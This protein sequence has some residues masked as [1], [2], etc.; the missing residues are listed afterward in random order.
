MLNNIIPKFIR[1]VPVVS[2]S[3][4]ILHVNWK[5][6]NGA[7]T[8]NKTLK[9]REDASGISNF[10][11]DK[12]LHCGFR[13]QRGLRKHNNNRH[14]WLYYFDQE[15]SVKRED[16]EKGEIVK[17]KQPTHTIPAFSTDDGI[18]KLFLRWLCTPCGG[19]KEMSQKSNEIFDGVHWRVC[20]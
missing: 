5:A 6:F 13:S 17:L 4:N 9:L 19:G 18:G 2:M 10:P 7:A 14:A 1:T 20:W 8:N 15:P 12:C 11:I 16:I 3:K